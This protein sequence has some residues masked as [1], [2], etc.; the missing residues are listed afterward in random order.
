MNTTEEAVAAA[1]RRTGVG[2]FPDAEFERAYQHDY[3]LRS[4]RPVRVA[5]A[6]AIGLF[7][8]FSTLDPFLLPGAYRGLLDR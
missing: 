5:I 7:I 1:T 3:F 6:L 2:Q 8:L 4:V